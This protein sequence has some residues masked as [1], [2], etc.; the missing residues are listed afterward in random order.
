MKV[1][2]ILATISFTAC[3]LLTNGALH[4]CTIS[5]NCTGSCET[6]SSEPCTPDCATPTMHCSGT[7]GHNAICAGAARCS[8][9][10]ETLRDRDRLFTR[11]QCVSVIPTCT[12]ET[13]TFRKSKLAVTPAIRISDRI[14]MKYA[15]DAHRARIR[16]WRAKLRYRLRLRRALKRA[17]EQYRRKMKAKLAARRRAQQKADFERRIKR[18]LAKAKYLEKLRKAAKGAK[19]M[20]PPGPVSMKSFREKVKQITDELYSLL[21]ELYKRNFVDGALTP[22][23]ADTEKKP[24][25]PAMTPAPTAKPVITMEPSPSALSQ[26]LPF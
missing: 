22:Q 8:V 18:E 25:A 14:R 7:C 15:R 20:P 24:P 2:I 3:I 5:G 1:A 26:V 23:E 19:P 6:S 4:Q 21:M 11:C 9:E 17:R 16:R 10:C 13:Y 12:C